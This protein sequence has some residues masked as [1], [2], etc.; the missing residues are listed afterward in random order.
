MRERRTHT[1][2]RFLFI[3]VQDLWFRFLRTLWR[4]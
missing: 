2:L 1:R 3:D 4:R